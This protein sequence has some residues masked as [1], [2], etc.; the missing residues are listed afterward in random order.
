MI[1]WAACDI[2]NQKDR[3]EYLSVKKY[4]AEILGEGMQL[5]P[6]VFV[7]RLSSLLSEML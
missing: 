4:I 3:C 5:L 7:L 6:L 2:N 1:L